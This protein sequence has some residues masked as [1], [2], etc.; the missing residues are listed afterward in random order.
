MAISTTLTQVSGGW[1]LV[2][3]DYTHSGDGRGGG[4]PEWWVAISTTLTQVR[5]VGWGGGMCLT[6]S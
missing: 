3:H 4:G 6:H 1:S 2:L 5:G